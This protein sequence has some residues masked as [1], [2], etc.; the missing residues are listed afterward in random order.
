MMP[1]YL[2]SKRFIIGTEDTIM[3]A[4]KNMFDVFYQEYYVPRRATLIAVGDFNV[5]DIMSL[6]EDHFGTVKDSRDRGDLVDY[7]TFSVGNGLRTN[8][9]VTISL[10]RMSCA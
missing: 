2:V 7:G 4:T 5:S 6:M 1:D 3:G 8:V 10:L 9:F